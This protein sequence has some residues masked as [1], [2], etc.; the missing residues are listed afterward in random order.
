MATLSR[1]H[2]V[3]YLKAP[4]SPHQ[5]TPIR[6]SLIFHS[7]SARPTS[8]HIHSTKAATPAKMTHPLIAPTNTFAPAFFVVMDG[9]AVV[10]ILPVADIVTVAVAVLVLILVLMLV[11]FVP[12]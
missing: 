11:E 5:L 6:C 8:H 7:T 1:R 12:F 10:V 9:D 2:V 4:S 3:Y